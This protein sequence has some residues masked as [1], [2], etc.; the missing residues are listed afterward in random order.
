MRA[1]SECRCSAS[2][3]I[4]GNVQVNNATRSNGQETVARQTQ[5][6]IQRNYVEPGSG[7]SPRCSA[8][9]GDRCIQALATSSSVG[10]GKSNSVQMAT[11]SGGKYLQIK[12]L[13]ASSRKDESSRHASNSGLTQCSAS[14][15]GRANVFHLPQEL[16]NN[17]RFASGERDIEHRAFGGTTMGYDLPIIN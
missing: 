14:N 13:R 15:D 12:T 5:I 8:S 16:S 6:V 4:D 1:R 17:H 11:P 3:R 9:S 10:I 7:R 2:R